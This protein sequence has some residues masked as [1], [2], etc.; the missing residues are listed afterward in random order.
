LLSFLDKK[1]L[2]PTVDP[3]NN[4]RK[5]ANCKRSYL[6]THYSHFSLQERI[7]REIGIIHNIQTNSRRATVLKVQKK[8]CKRNMAE[9]V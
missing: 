9:K 7:K 1:T 3:N 8:V 2:I 4:K 5:E 6:Q